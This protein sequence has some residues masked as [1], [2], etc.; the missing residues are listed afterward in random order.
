[1]QAKQTG[2]GRPTRQQYKPI[3]KT[4]QQSSP[5]GAAK[6][7]RQGTTS[8]NDNLIKK[9]LLEWVSVCCRYKLK[10]VCERIDIDAPSRYRVT[11]HLI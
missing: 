2:V 3:G 11:T 7:R 5:T 6:E 8:G 4:G 1:V 9:V 10:I